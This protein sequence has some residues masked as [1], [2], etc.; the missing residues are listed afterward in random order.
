LALA[1]ELKEFYLGKI[2]I[3]PQIVISGDCGEAYMASRKNQ[4]AWDS[5]QRIVRK[6]IASNETNTK[7][8]H[9]E[10]G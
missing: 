8:N 5:F 6:I 3:E 1:N 7:N 10:T 9:G 2:P 4:S